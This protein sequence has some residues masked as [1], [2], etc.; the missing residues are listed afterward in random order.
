M[1][2]YERGTWASTRRPPRTA[3]EA[4]AVLPWQRSRAVRYLLAIRRRADGSMDPHDTRLK[5]VRI[6]ARRGEGTP[7]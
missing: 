2:S 3:T 5:R 7:T 4:V 6:Q 1:T